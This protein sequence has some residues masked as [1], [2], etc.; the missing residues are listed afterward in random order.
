MWVNDEFDDI[1]VT[2]DYAGAPYNKWIVSLMRQ[3]GLGGGEELS[4]LAAFNNKQ[5]AIK[6]AIGWMKA[7]PRIKKF[8]SSAFG[9]HKK[10]VEV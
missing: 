8:L 10:G 2:V 9:I 4:E 3:V 7:R 5:N 1:Y 6:Y